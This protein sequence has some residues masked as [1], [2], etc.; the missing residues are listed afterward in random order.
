MFRTYLS[1]KM[2]R[3]NGENWLTS[4]TVY[5][6]AFRP[7]TL[8]LTPEFVYSL[9][10]PAYFAIRDRQYFSTIVTVTGTICE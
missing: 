4:R 5:F 2:I 8:D 6:Y 1:S 3:R 7:S 10:H 9:D